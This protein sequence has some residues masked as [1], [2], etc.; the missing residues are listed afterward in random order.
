[1]L[2]ITKPVSVAVIF[3]QPDGTVV[4]ASAITGAIA[5]AL[6]D[7]IVTATLSPDFSTLTISPVPGVTGVAMVQVDASIGPTSFDAGLIQVHK[8]GWINVHS[9]G[10]IQVHKLGWINVHSTIDIVP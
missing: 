4:P 7:G 1:M 8:L 3:H 5:N 10:L 6:P 9:T 2:Q